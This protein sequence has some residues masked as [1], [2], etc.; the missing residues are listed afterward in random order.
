MPRVEERLLYLSG[1]D[2]GE[3]ECQVVGKDDDAT[4]GFEHPV[5]LCDGPFGVF[6]VF[7]NL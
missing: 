6:K 3:L 7:D 5:N 4:A 2:S 1:D